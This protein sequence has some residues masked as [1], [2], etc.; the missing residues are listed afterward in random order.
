MKKLLILIVF[1]SSCSK[2]NL[3]PEEASNLE[4]IT[5]LEDVAIV[6]SSS[7]FEEN[8]KNKIVVVAGGTIEEG[9]VVWIN[10]KKI[11]LL[12]DALEATGL[13]YQ[14]NKIYVTGWTYGGKGSVWIMDLD[15][16]NQTVME[17]EGKYSE[18]QRIM[19]HNGD[20][21]TGG[22][23]DNGS[24]YWKNGSKIDLTKE[25]FYC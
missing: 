24:C 22:F 18:G 4:D 13:F 5:N 15:G 17:L 2:E 8:F 7:F 11:L 25:F 14:D 6:G 21:Y 19:V 12:N 1:F 10:N 9:A 16:S 20:I 3:N 23:F